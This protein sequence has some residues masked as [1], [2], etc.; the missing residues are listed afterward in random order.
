M[1]SRAMNILREK[2]DIAS[3]DH[4]KKRF[5]FASVIENNIALR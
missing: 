5:I 4:F 2:Y 3:R 1:A